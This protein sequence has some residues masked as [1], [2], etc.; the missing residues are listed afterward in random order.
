MENLPVPAPDGFRLLQPEPLWKGSV[1]LRG[2]KKDVLVSTLRGIAVKLHVTFSGYCTGKVPDFYNYHFV[3]AREKESEK[4][5]PVH[6][7]ERA[8]RALAIE[9]GGVP[10]I[11][12]ADSEPFV[13]TVL[14]LQGEDVIKEVRLELQRF[15]ITPASILRVTHNADTPYEGLASVV[16]GDRRDIQQVMDTAKRTQQKRFTIEDLQKTIGYTYEM[17]TDGVIIGH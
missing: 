2:M 16:M 12:Q 8:L 4:L 3:R 15:T 5:P 11:E 13:R 10:S 6:Q 17:R 14:G 1:L 7:F 9:T